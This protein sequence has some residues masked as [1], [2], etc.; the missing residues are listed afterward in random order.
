MFYYSGRFKY[1][2]VT[3]CLSLA[4][5]KPTCV[6]TSI[7]YN[8]E[9]DLTFPETVIRQSAVTLETCPDGEVD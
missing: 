4:V 8:A 5:V 9:R 3:K 2:F 6:Q 7:N 1:K